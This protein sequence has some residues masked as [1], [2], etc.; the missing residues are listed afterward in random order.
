MDASVF[1]DKPTYHQDARF[2]AT[3][4]KVWGTQLGKLSNKTGD[5]YNQQ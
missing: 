1:L 2:E 5:L 4:M 3:K